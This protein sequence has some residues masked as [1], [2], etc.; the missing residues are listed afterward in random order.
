MIRSHETKPVEQLTEENSVPEQNKNGVEPSVVFEKGSSS[1]IATKQEGLKVIVPGVANKPIV[2]VEGARK[3]RVIIKPAFNKLKSELLHRETRLR[4][5]VDGEK[6]LR[7]LCNE[8]E[9]ELAHLRYEK[10]M[11]DLERL[12]SEVGQAKCESHE[13]KARV[14]TQVAAKKDALAKAS[15]LE[16]KLCNARDAADA[17]AELMGAIDQESRS[18]EFVRCQSCRETLEEIHARGF[19][20]SEEIKQAK[21]NEYDAK[22]LLSDAE[23]SEKE[24]NGP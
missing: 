20:L 21:A 14:D 12:W 16:V 13:L 10:K 3:E 1:K 22:F 6:S 2:V 18:K 24:A 8:R 19:D 17:R 23:D 9:D 5:V 7:L 11:E 4:K 15:A